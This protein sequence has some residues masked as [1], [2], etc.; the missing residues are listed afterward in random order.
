MR[1]RRWRLDCCGVSEAS[2]SSVKYF[3]VGRYFISDR[4]TG[5]PPPTPPQG[6]GTDTHPQPLPKGGELTPTPFISDRR[7]KG[8]D[9]P[10]LREGRGGL[11][12]HPQPL[13]KG[14]ECRRLGEIRPAL[15]LARFQNKVEKERPKT[16]QP[17]ATP[18]ELSETNIRPEWAKELLFHALP[19]PLCNGGVSFFCPLRGRI[20]AASS[21]PGR[22]PGLAYQCPFGA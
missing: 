19:L 15:E 14:G 8:Q 3:Q 17:K 10:S 11:L 5:Y 12:H 22:C 6:R 21:S 2:Q 1:I 18:W 20:P 16:S 7:T 13:P 9:T 4:R